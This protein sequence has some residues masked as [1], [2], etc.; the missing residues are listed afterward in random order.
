VQVDNIFDKQY[1]DLL[2]SVMP[3]RWVMGGFKVML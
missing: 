1:S 2:G 3:K